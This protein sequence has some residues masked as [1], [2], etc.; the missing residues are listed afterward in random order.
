M[1]GTLAWLIIITINLKDI[2]NI[3]RFFATIVFCM[4]LQ[5]VD[6]VQA[7][8]RGEGEQPGDPVENLKNR[9]SYVE[10]KADALEAAVVGLAAWKVATAGGTRSYPILAG[11]GVLYTT[12]KLYPK[13]GV[14]TGNAFAALLMAGGAFA[15]KKANLSDSQ[16]GDPI[17]QSIISGGATAVTTGLYLLN[18]N[19]M[20]ENPEHQTN[21]AWCVGAAGF[22]TTV[23][24][25]LISPE[26]I[27]VDARR[28]MFGLGL[29][30]TVLGLKLTRTAFKKPSE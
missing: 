8:G 9:V 12:L 11:A 22:I 29:G 25:L 1:H 28:K 23:G 13:L 4:C 2:M 30:S 20:F 17:N 18:T 16:M 14:K 24:S 7:M 19:G 5:S 10:K 26:T 3:N 6:S 27:S 21:L 15:I